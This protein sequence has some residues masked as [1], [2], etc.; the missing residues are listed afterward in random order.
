MGSLFL[1][2]VPDDRQTSTVMSYGPKKKN[3]DMNFLSVSKSP[4][5]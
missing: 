4:R 5:K 3:P 1:A 2:K